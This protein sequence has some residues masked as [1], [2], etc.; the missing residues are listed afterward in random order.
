ML[1]PTEK[2]HYP[3]E[4]GK[5]I[6][7]TV[8]T[9]KDILT[10][11]ET[12]WEVDKRPI[13]ADLVNGRQTLPAEYDVALVRLDDP[14]ILS[15]VKG[16]YTPI[17]NHESA[18]FLIDLLDQSES[19][20][21]GGGELLNGRMVWYTIMMPREIQL[22]GVPDDV[23]YSTA[24]V[25]NDHGGGSFKARTDAWRQV[26]TNGLVAPVPGLGNTYKI[27]H[28]TSAKQ[29]LAEVKRFLGFTY[30]YFDGFEEAMQQLLDSPANKKTLTKTVE[31]IWK[32]PDK[33]AGQKSKSRWDNRF[34]EIV[35]VY[36]HSENVDNF[37]KTRWG[38][39]NAVTEWSQWGR[40]F[41]GA[42]RDESLQDVL[43]PQEMLIGQSMQISEKAF[44]HLMAGV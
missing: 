6:D 8:R 28:T 43:R 42:A 4:R 40:V 38:V 26:C 44:T 10:A 7:V 1:A 27:R 21:G 19:R 13:R 24:T 39:Y 30:L 41:Y 18:Q 32:R 25:V 36:E 12:D 3:W 17:Q 35:S 9:A 14:R 11:T 16:R 2:R 34:E 20:L 37:R 31:H 23:I 22:P 5:G 15:T 33:D 29:R